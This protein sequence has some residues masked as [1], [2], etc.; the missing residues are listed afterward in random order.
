MNGEVL[1]SLEKW[2]MGVDLER[3][4]LNVVFIVGI[5]LR[6]DICGWRGC[7][8]RVNFSRGGKVWIGEYID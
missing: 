6:E 3:R 2:E 1:L 7:L 4:R 5:I 8:G